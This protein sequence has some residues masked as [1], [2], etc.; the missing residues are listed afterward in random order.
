[1]DEKLQT[2]HRA[3]MPLKIAARALG[4]AP[5]TVRVM[6]QMGVVSWGRAFKRPESK[7]YSYLISPKTFYEETGF[8]W[9]EENEYW[10]GETNHGKDDLY[11]RVE[12]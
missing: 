7:K 8:L 4:M 11:S 1:M 6:I 3:N 12:I 10:K 2:F 9:D 5:Q